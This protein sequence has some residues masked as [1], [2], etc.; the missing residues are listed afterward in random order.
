M[1]R[2]LYIAVIFL[3]LGCRKDI[4]PQMPEYT[5]KVVIEASI[6][7]GSTAVVFLSY[8]VPY[9]GDFD[10]S[11]PE[12]AFISG[13]DV[14]ISDGLRS[15]KLVQPDPNNG[16]LYLGTQIVGQQGKTYSL[17]VTVKGKTY[18]AV[19]SI[20]TPPKLDSLYFKVDRDS[21]GYMWQRFSEPEGR[22]QCYRWFA[23]RLGRDLFY[24]APFNSVFD[25]QFIDGKSF[26][27]GYDR[28]PQPNQLQRNREDPERGYYKMGDTIVV[29]FCKIGIAEYRFWNTYYQNK[30]SNGNPFSAPVNIQ[31]MYLQYEDAFGAFT[32]YSPRFDTIVIP[33]K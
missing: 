15:E 3:V 10:Y 4:V 20:G 9:F 26:D 18:E 32:G 21:L 29:K 24:A 7:T 5:Q 6:E 23:K 22:G 14:V 33:K 11:A 8:S 28:G 13:A 25:D 27:F 1:K 17:K 2:I 31:H 12:K 30:S 19:T 16:Y